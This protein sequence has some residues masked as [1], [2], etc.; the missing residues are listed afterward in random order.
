M[1]L[2]LYEPDHPLAREASSAS[3]PIILT[4]IAILTLFFCGIVVWAVLA[5]LHVAIN[6]PAEVV[7]QNKRKAVQHLEGGIVSR[8]LV[9]DGELVELGQPLIMLENSQVRPLV[10]MLEEQ[11]LAET[12]TMARLEAESKDLDAIAFPPSIASRATDPAIARIVGV[13]N[14]LFAARHKVFQNQLELLRLQ[15]AQIKETIKGGRE[16]LGS[17][18]QEIAALEEQ[19]AANRAL[20]KEGY[21][22]RTVVLQLQGALAEK[23][24]ELEGISAAIANDQQRMAEMDQRIA[25]VRAERIQTAINELKQSSLR[26]IDL[27][28]RIRP[29]RDVLD[30]QVIRAPVTGKVVGLKVTTVGGIILPREPLMEIAPVDDRLILEAKINLENISDVKLGQL[31]EVKIFGFNVRKTPKLEA[32]LTYLSDDRIVSPSPQ[33]PQ[34]HYLALLEFEQSSLDSLG[35]LELVPGMSAEV[36]IATQPR[37]AFDFLFEPLHDR[38]RKALNAK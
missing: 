36:S 2:M 16:R 27:E 26:R 37:S 21:V 9:R 8:I 1:P 31:A 22:T 11:I 19:L 28:E 29:T 20:Q 17:K 24:G 18:Q 10:N 30:R 13:E 14:N 4:G 32:R 23:V 25:S 3:F 7:F 5:P 35:D 12:A 33:G 38:L 6:A 34:S 15:I